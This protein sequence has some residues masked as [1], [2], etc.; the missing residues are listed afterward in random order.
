M[1]GSLCRCER[2]DANT[3]N[4]HQ[5]ASSY[6]LQFLRTH[7]LEWCLFYSSTAPAPST[8]GLFGS[9][10]GK[11]LSLSISMTLLLFVMSPLNIIG[12]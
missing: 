2:S 9:T 11:K 7:A 4:E 8:G 6:L 5:L 12:Y 3:V 10:P 1:G